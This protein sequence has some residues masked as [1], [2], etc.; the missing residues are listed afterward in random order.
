MARR[1]RF[2]MVVDS[3]DGWVAPPVSGAGPDAAAGAPWDGEAVCLEDTAFVS[4]FEA[5]TDRLTR[6]MTRNDSSFSSVERTSASESPVRDVMSLSVTR[7]SMR[8]RMNPS[9]ADK[10]K[11][12]IARASPTTFGIF[13]SSANRPP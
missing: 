5:S 3:L 4:P 10:R 9:T 6:A 11:D 12:D 8:E 13:G 7:P 1:I 2:A